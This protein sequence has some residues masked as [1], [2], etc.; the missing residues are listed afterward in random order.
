[1]TRGYK[2]LQRVPRGYRWLQDWLQEVAGGNTGVTR[3]NK[4]L[5]GV[6]AGYKGLKWV[7][8]IRKGYRKL[9][10]VTRA[11]RGLQGVTGDYRR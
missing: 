6:R 10:G 7:T 2:G 4:R 9:Q 11:D 1:M 8:G 5:Q 3:N